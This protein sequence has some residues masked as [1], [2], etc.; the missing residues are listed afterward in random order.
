MH[1]PQKDPLNPKLDS[2]FRSAL[3]CSGF[4]SSDPDNQNIVLQ[5]IYNHAA[6]ELVITLC[7]QDFFTL[8]R[9][10]KTKDHVM[11]AYCN[12]MASM[13]YKLMQLRRGD[14][15]NIVNVRLD[16]LSATC[17][18]PAVFPLC[19]GDHWIALMYVPAGFKDTQ[20]P[21]LYVYDSLNANIGSPCISQSTTAFFKKNPYMLDTR[22]KTNIIPVHGLEQVYDNE[23]GQLVL[24]ACTIW[25]TKNTPDCKYITTN[26][27]NLHSSQSHETLW[28]NI[29]QTLFTQKLHVTTV[30]N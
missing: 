6:R 30:A 21:V 17:N 29:A 5:K 8:R 7:V 25:A 9:G 24:H 12:L 3:V 10:H 18:I 16:F 28:E 14:I 20:S 22:A 13:G 23:C 15:L 27:P 2:I 1:T 11:Q 4:N 26:L 19:T